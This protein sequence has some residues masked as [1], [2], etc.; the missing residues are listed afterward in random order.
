MKLSS[1][2]FELS[3]TKR[4]EYSSVLMNRFGG[5]IEFSQFVRI[6]PEPI[7]ERFEIEVGNLP[8]RP[9]KPVIEITFEIRETGCDVRPSKHVDSRNVITPRL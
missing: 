9:T 2:V 6:H 8:E 7:F 1:N 5:G 4:D 3:K